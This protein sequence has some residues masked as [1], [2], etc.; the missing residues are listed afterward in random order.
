MQPM[1]LKDAKTIIAFADASMNVSLAAH[2]VCL[3]PVSFSRELDII[4]V[5]YDINPRNFYGLHRL[6]EM[7]VDCIADNKTEKEKDNGNR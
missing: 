5:R 1:T 2:A 4:R 6:L 3:D 7:A